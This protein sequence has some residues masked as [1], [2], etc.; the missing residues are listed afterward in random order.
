MERIGVFFFRGSHEEWA[1]PWLLLWLFG[2]FLGITQ[3]P[4]VW[5]LQQQATF[6]W[7]ETR[8]LKVALVCFLSSCRKSFQF[9]LTALKLMLS[10]ASVTKRLTSDFG[11]DISARWWFQMFF[12]IFTPTWRNDPIWLI[13]FKGVETTNQ[14]LVTLAGIYQGF[15]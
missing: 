13:F 15:W 8:V 9:Y 7:K 6:W 5:G 4:L 10:S 14:T 12:F 3:Y 11:R 1:K 2:L